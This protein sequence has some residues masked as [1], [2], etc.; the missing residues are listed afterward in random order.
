M[1]LVERLYEEAQDDIESLYWKAAA[2]IDRLNELLSMPR[3][4]NM[5]YETVA[6]IIADRDR[7]RV[8]LEAARDWLP[9]HEPTHPE[10][11]GARS[12]AGR[13]VRL[14]LELEREI[15]S[16][17]GAVAHGNLF[18]NTCRQCMNVRIGC[19]L[20]PWPYAAEKPCGA[21]DVQRFIDKLD[22]LSNIC[23]GDCAWREKLLSENERMKA[24]LQRI[25][26]NISGDLPA[27][28]IAGEAVRPN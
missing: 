27:Q 7:L 20:P 23:L 16:E 24:A 11:E 25:A 10:Y 18:C 1:E 5:E 28:V 9:Y 21:E 26:L 22:R 15:C 19:D 3:G 13:L 14:A 12:D 17:C 8:A 2:E 4:V 6:D